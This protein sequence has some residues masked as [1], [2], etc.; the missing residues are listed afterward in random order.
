MSNYLKLQAQIQK[1]QKEAESVKKR[2]LTETI[3]NI[4]KAIQI[5]D[6]TAADV[7]ESLIEL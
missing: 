4:K 5:F 2:E 1:L 6:F 7:C 3:S